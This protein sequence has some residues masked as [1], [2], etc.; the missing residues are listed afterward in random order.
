MT[1]IKWCPVCKGRI[2]TTGQMEKQLPCEK[3][4][5]HAEDFHR[6]YEIEKKE[7]TWVE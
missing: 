7:D 1:W 6:L 5:K 3:C 2:L 4:Q